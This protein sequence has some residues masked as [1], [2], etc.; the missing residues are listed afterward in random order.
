MKNNYS[1]EESLKHHKP[2]TFEMPDEIERGDQCEYARHFATWAKK[3]CQ[4]AVQEPSLIS[5]NRA[6]LLLIKKYF[7]W[8]ES[9]PPKHRHQIGETGHVCIFHILERAYHR[10]KVEELALTPPMLFEPVQPPA[11]V[12]VTKKYEL[13]F[14]LGEI[15]DEED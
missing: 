15:E 6:M 14:P 5:L 4:K 11:P 3:T 2:F 9:V 10:L 12:Y 8:R 1:F 7:E 13:S